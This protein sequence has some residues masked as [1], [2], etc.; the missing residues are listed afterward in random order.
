M[1]VAAAATIPSGA[2]E[3]VRFGGA[4]FDPFPW[5]CVR[6]VQEPRRRSV[7]VLR[8]HRE[9]TASWP[10][11]SRAFR[12]PRRTSVPKEVSPQRVVRHTRTCISTSIFCRFYDSIL[13]LVFFSPLERSACGFR[14][15]S[16]GARGVCVCVCGS[17]VQCAAATGRVS[18]RVMNIAW[19]NFECW[20]WPEYDGAIVEPASCRDTFSSNNTAAD[21]DSSERRPKSMH[22]ALLA[23]R[24]PHAGA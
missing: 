24:L 3:V 7:L 10:H 23:K 9:H 22:T 11:R 17:R 20:R 18:R 21:D 5:K 4:S 8:A 12:F 16:A 15:F 1:V 19:P 13:C 2:V 6:R 14:V